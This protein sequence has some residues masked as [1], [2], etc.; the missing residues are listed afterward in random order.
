MTF[1]TSTGRNGI[2]LEDLFVDPS[3]RG[4][5]AGTALLRRLARICVERG[6]R[7][8]EW[9]VLTWN[10]PSIAFYRSLG[11]VPKSDW[12]THRIDGAA[13]VSLAEGSAATD[14]APAATCR[15][16]RR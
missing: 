15:P 8:L 2:W 3:H 13:L 14:A 12:E 9:C 6:W 10:E 4:P 1:P 11:A 7:W 5:G 16:E